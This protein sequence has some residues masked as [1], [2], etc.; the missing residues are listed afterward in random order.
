[1]LKEV[2]VPI[3]KM[4]NKLTDPK[5]ALDVQMTLPEVEGEREVNMLQ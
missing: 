2:T 5:G 3:E 1:M 4:A